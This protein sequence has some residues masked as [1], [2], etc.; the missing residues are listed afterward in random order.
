MQH[1]VICRD[2]LL[3]HPSL[4]KS[5]QSFLGCDSIFF[6]SI[7][8][9]SRPRFLCGDRSFF[10]SLTNFPVRSIVLS[11]LCRNDLMCVYWN[12]YVATL[13][14]MLRYCFC[15]ASSNLCCSLVSM[16]QQYFWLFLLQQCFLY[17][18]HSYRD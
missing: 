8:I 10:G 2:M 13:T 15:T 17:R 1:A 3:V 7:F 14:I 6:F 18:Q 5:Q 11:I 16:L 9:L 12:S 4:I